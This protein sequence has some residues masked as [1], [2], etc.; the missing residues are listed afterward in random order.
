MQGGIS[1]E[2]VLVVGALGLMAAYIIG[3]VMHG[4]M[5]EQGLGGF[6][7]AVVLACGFALGVAAAGRFGYGAIGLDRLTVLAIGAAFAALL[8]AAIVKRLLLRL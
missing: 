7:N 8:L 4:V 5:G 6:G 3:Q 2:F 1:S